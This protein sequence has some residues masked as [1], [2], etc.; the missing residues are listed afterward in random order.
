M[1]CRDGQGDGAGL[2]TGTWDQTSRPPHLICDI[3]A[4]PEPDKSFDAV[5]CT[6]VLEHVPDPAQALRELSR[7]LKPGGVLLLT[8]P[9]CSIAHFTPY[10]F[11]TGFSR[12][13]YETHLAGLGFDLLEVSP[14]GSYFDYVAQELRRLPSVI[15][16]HC[17]GFA[18]VL[19]LVAHF[20]L[21]FPLL[22]ILGWI[23]RRDRGSSALL[24][25]G[26]HVM[27]RRSA[28]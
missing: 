4:I 10:H 3:T 26:Y 1:S 27:A 20:L 9:F 19:Y 18:L 7:L 6:E 13:W 15:K 28:P 21:V 11:S 12:Y 16:K 24:C 8:A 5:L 22:A 14:N 25:F 23:S 2:Q 17:T